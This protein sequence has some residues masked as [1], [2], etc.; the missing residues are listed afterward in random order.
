MALSPVIDR[1]AWLTGNLAPPAAAVQADGSVPCFSSRNRGA[2]LAATNDRSSWGERDVAGRHR[3]FRGE[4]RC[5]AD[6]VLPSPHPVADRRR[7]G[8]RQFR[9]LSRRRGARA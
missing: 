1:W 6:V 4:A 7:N 5:L 2:I 9:Y 8:L 3:Q